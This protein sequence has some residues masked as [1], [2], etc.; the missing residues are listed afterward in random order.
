MLQ[1]IG[2]SQNWNVSFLP[3]N[4]YF[5]LKCFPSKHWTFISVL[6][7]LLDCSYK[8]ILQASQNSKDLL[9]WGK[10]AAEVEPFEGSEKNAAIATMNEAIKESLK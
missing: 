2:L 4:A 9:M 10:I 5:L 6:C 1:V 3:K 7:V 8:I